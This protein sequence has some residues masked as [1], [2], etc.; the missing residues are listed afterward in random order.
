LTP[1]L[2][3]SKWLT[4]L[5]LS[6]DSLSDA[7]SAA[8]IILGSRLLPINDFYFHPLTTIVSVLFFLFLYRLNHLFK[9]FIILAVFFGLKP[10]G[11][12]RSP[13]YVRTTAFEAVS[14]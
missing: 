10:L 11:L 4:E 8:Q 6:R 12:L 1:F 9:K 13:A 5:S 3:A 2:S 7:S 14:N